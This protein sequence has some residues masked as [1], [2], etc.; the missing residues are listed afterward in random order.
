MKSVKQFLYLLPPVFK[1]RLTILLILL[2][3]GMLFEMMGLGM[4]VPALS[5]IIEN[6]IP[7]KYPGLHSFLNTL[8]VTDQRDLIFFGF[9][10]LTIVYFVKTIV[11]GYLY[12]KQSKFNADLSAEFSH[13]LFKGYLNQPYYFHLQRNSS[14]LLKNIQGEVIQLNGVLQAFGA[15]LLEVAMILGIF[16]VLIIIE[17]FAAMSVTIVLALTSFLFHLFSK[18]K[19]LNWGK[20]RQF[21][22]G[23][24]NQHLMQGLGGV[25]DVLMMGKEKYFI[26]KFREHNKERAKSLTKIV[27]IGLMPRL[28]LEFLSVFGLSGVIIV[29]IAQG[30][31]IEGMIPVIAVF[32]AAAFRLIPSANRI[33]TSVQAFR[34]AVPVLELFYNEF[35]IIKD[36]GNS[37]NFTKSKLIFNNELKLINVDY[38]YPNSKS[39]SLKDITFTIKRGE[40]IGFVGP[41]GSG[42]STLLDIILGLLHPIN[43]EITVDGIN[44]KS[45]L[46]GWQDQ[47]GYIPQ[48]IY[49]TDDTISRNVAFG[50]SDEDINIDKVIISL[51]AAQLYE[52]VEKLP[53]KLDTFVG[54]RGV[55]MSGGQRQ[56]IGIARALYH[57]PQILVLDEATSALDNKTEKEVMEALN[58]LQGIKTLVIVAHRVSTIEQCDRIFELKNGQIISVKENYLNQNLN[59]VR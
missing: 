42:K 23:K 28:Y 5:L 14:Q 1:K 54:E 3:F 7:N 30:K 51:R 12:Y 48:S 52:F 36:H 26:N 24:I 16:I 17:P 25:K 15:L 49:L 22:D 46:R 47:I 55:R 44:I 38:R 37:P 35:R 31:A 13:I 43:G 29:M 4:L 45:N 57:D 59:Q 20:A 2:F 39:N 32:V 40:S 27:T 19:I 41:S 53:N 8:G 50:V 11:L 6:D 10:L 56:R 21:H 34:F 33:V 18:T 9:S 58:A